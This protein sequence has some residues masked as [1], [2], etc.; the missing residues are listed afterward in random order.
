M[1]VHSSG[2]LA[3]ITRAAAAVLVVGEH[4][5]LSG[6]TALELHGLTAAA[7]TDVHITVAYSKRPRS[8]PGLVV[9]QNRFDPADVVEL[10]GLPVFCL[11]QAL[12]DFV[13]DGD[14]LTAIA[15]LDQALNG[16]SPEQAREF[17][18]DVLRRL[19]ARLDRRGVSTGLMV[20]HLA[21]GKADSPPE[22]M[23]R[24]V[25]VEAGFPI[26]EAQ[27]EILTIDGR[28]LYV[29]DLA[30]PEVRI[31]L[32]YDGYAAHEGRESQDSERDERMAGRGWITVRATYADLR[33]PSR[34]IS[35][36]RAA[37]AKR[38]G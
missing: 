12:A 15:C 21:D 19:H 34:L 14:R 23:L 38:S 24:L 28:R 16:L 33:D 31:A 26:P 25:V 7:S 3:P 18:A 30:W 35:E 9:H 13:C 27:Y 2:A 6:L 4:G 22:S 8:R 20:L 36:L 10:D 37:F 29:L 5:V 32:E 1:I 17:R 11:P